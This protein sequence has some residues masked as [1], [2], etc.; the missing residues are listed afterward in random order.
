[1]RSRQMHQLAARLKSKELQK[2]V[3]KSSAVLWEQQVNSKSGLWV[4]YTPHYHKIISSD[5]R[6]REA[7]FIDV[8]SDHISGN[9]LTL[10]KQVWQNLA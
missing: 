9:G 6:I 4:D 2:Q 10:V 7:K 1:M 8:V 3:G 5:A